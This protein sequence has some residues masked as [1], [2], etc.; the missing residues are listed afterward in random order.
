M[1]G[2]RAG[3][4]LVLALAVLTLGGQAGDA[5]R[6]KLLPL[7]TPDEGNATV[8]RVA[9][10]VLPRK[11]K[12]LS[13]KTAAHV[14]LSHPEQLRGPLL[15][16]GAAAQTR[17]PR[18]YH[19]DAFVVLLRRSGAPLGDASGLALEAR[20]TGVAATAF[21]LAGFTAQ[22]LPNA[23]GAAAPSSLCTALKAA[24]KKPSAVAFDDGTKTDKAPT[25][26]QKVA[27]ARAAAGLCNGGAASVAAVDKLLAPLGGG[28]LVPA[29]FTPGLAAGTWKG[30]WTNQ[31]FGTTGSLT[32]AIDA[33]GGV[34]TFAVAPTGNVF[35]C[36]TPA[37]ETYTVTQGA[38][39]NHWNADGFDVQ[40]ASAAFGQLEVS[41]AYPSGKL[42]GH[43]ANP[44]CFSGLSWTLDGA[45]TPNA[46][47]GT[48]TISLPG[49][50]SA[51][52]KIALTRS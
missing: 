11:G 15:L 26:A 39:A 3:A 33:S 49:G 20:V 21:M 44:S 43:G 32:F 4:A 28:T 5:A 48:V 16:T 50:L 1:I 35:G 10:D 24:T 23:I 36:A 12:T 6:Q 41:L 17:K 22:T 37:P 19:F 31:T 18:R 7:P 29:G 46:I 14:F 30:T 42:T 40:A 38:G 47:D 52:T 13:R 27:L 25:A 8:V 51:T 9:F 2:R 34:L 45:A